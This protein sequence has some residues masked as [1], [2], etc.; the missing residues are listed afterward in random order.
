MLI[1]I[2]IFA[3]FAFLALFTNFL[4]LHKGSVL[5]KNN[6]E[7]LMS[8]FQDIQLP[9]KIMAKNVYDTPNEIIGEDFEMNY[10][11]KESLFITGEKA[12]YDKKTKIIDII[13]GTISFNDYIMYFKSGYFNTNNDT[14]NCMDFSL[15][16]KD[17]QMSSR[18]AIIDFA[19]KKLVAQDAV[20]KSLK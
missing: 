9:F 1:I 12:V 20:I 5:N 17:E 11:K 14:L 8:S 6:S 7:N 18:T 15:R 13:S 3:L 4:I 10:N 16:G 2:L 19:H